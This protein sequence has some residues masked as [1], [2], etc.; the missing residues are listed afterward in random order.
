MIVIKNTFKTTVFLLLLC[1]QSYGQNFHPKKLQKTLRIA[2]EKAYGASVR[3]WGFDT[4]KK[5]QTSAQFSGVV[6]TA[7]GHILTAA[8]VN[9]PGNTYLVTFPNG[10]SHIALGLGEIEFAENKNFPDVA[11]MKMIGEAVWPHAEMGWSSS[12]KL[13]EPC[14]SIAYP[15]TLNQPL[16]TIRFGRITNKKNEFGFIQSTCI[17]EPG[18]SGGPLFDHLGRVIALHSAIGIVEDDNY[19]IPVDFYRKYWTALNILKTYSSLPSIE[20]AIGNDPHRSAI[21]NSPGLKDL[22]L[23]FAP[24]ST[25]LKVS[26]LRISSMMNGKEQHV[27]G[28]L[29]S[30]PQRSAGSNIFSS[31]IISKSSL[32]GDHP[33]VLAENKSFVLKVIS[34]DP[35]NDL[36][37]LQ[38][39]STI[40]GGIQLKQFNRDSLTFQKLG[41]FLI[42][43]QSDQPD[44]ISIIGSMH[45]KS[46]KRFSI[47]YLGAMATFKEAN[48]VITAVQPNSPAGVSGIEVGDQVLSINGIAINKPE[49]YGAE[50]VKFWPYDHLKFKIKRSDSLY[51]KNLTLDFYRPPLSNHPAEQFSG[52]KSIRRDGF[53]QV[54]SHDAKVKPDECG[55]PVFDINNSFRGINIARSSR[56]TT[57]VIP[58]VV[59]LRLIGDYQSNLMAVP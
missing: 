38:P 44:Q 56:T 39:L 2:I 30:V 12:L 7:E 59:V 5:V 21:M 53:N 43:P 36:V 24:Q 37:L 20:D 10:K 48:I 25:Q 8:H 11:I 13:D 6:V 40:K 29:L 45:F 51:S 18:D 41:E 23:S 58:A 16:P 34:R 33:I 46:P 28:T 22:Q 54:F 15:E 3:I 32:I 17:M 35:E 1:A 14:L 4:L 42:S 27:N 47:G 9:Q 57:L 55:G 19:E 52:G 26:C 49:D 31:L 50:L